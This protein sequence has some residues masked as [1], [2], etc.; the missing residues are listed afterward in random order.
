MASGRCAVAAWR[1]TRSAFLIAL[2]LERPCEM[3][4]TPLTPSTGD[5]A[6]FFVVELLT[7]A[8]EGGPG[9]RGADR[10]D[11]VRGQLLADGLQEHLAEAL[12]ELEHDVA[13]EAI[14]DHHVHRRRR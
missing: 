11:G 6:V 2:A 7:H 14:A 1:A 12:A 5:A 8:V 9:E 10:A 4:E 3:I 13:D